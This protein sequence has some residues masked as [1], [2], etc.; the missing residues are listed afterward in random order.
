MT[1]LPVEDGQDGRLPSES[2]PAYYEP[3]LSDLLIAALRDDTD[4]M[5]LLD[6]ARKWTV[7]KLRDEISRF[8]QALLRLGVDRHRSVAILSGNRAEVLVMAG[9]D[10]IVGYSLTPLHP[11]GSLEDQAFMVEDAEVDALIFDPRTFQDRARELRERRPGLLLVALGPSTVGADLPALAEHEQAAPLRPPAVR[12]EDI[13]RV[14]YTGGTTGRPKGVVH[15]FRNRTAL[16]NVM[17]AE[18]ELPRA[19]R[20]LVCAPLSHAAGAFFLPV[21]LHRG[22]L[23]ILPKFDADQVLE[24]IQE[25]RITSIML[26]PTM[27]YALLD[28]PRLHEFDLSS[29]RI[30]YYGA[31]PMSPA[32]LREAIERLGPI[33]FQFYG[34]AEAP[35]TLTLL[36]REEHDPANLERLASCGRPVPWVTVE[37][38]DEEGRPGE[39]GE[40]CVRGPLT[41]AGY[42]DRP[43]ETAEALAG[44]WLHTGDLATRDADGFL[45]IVDRRKDMIVSGGFNVYPR[46]IEDILGL[47]P[48]VGAAAV[49]GVPHERWGEAVLAVVVRRPGASVTAEELIALVREH[50]GPIAAPKRVEFVDA[51]PLTDVGKPDKKALR[52]RYWATAD[53]R[54]H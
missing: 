48:A 18:W 47:H 12:P 33:F 40:I 44:G 49:I 42:L 34:Q 2:R 46:E 19:T 36:R 14:G 32:R 51:L 26:V 4:R 17:L 11:L 1:A 53:R 3:L 43:A 7:G 24:A 15:T 6:G 41:M 50:K 9:V 20:H 23:V 45:T 54:V 8:S 37:L 16:L 10:L 39:A 52:S 35:M 29:L 21:L 13:H 38:L 22:S 31:S 28:S 27:L 5:A 25:H 30:V